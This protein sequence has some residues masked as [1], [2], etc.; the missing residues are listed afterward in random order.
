MRILQKNSPYE[1]KLTAQWMEYPEILRK[2]IKS[3]PVPQ[4]RDFYVIPPDKWTRAE[5][6]IAFIELEC[7]VPEGSLVG[8]KMSLLPFQRMFIR[9]VYDNPDTATRRAIL[10]M[11]RKNGKTSLVAPLVLAHIVGPEANRNSQIVSGAMSMRQ[12]GVLMDAMTKIIRFNPN[13]ESRS[14]ITGKFVRGIAKNVNY[15]CLARDG[16]TAQGLSPNVA[17][18]DEVGQIV[19]G[20]DKFVEAITTAQGAHHEPLLFAI[21]TQAAS[22]SDLLS[23]WID[24]AQRSEDPSTICHVYEADADCDLLDEEQWIKANPALGVFRNEQDLRVNL[25]RAARVPS[26]EAGARNLLLNQRVSLQTLAVSPQVWKKNGKEVNHDLFMREPVH[27]GLD[28]SSRNDLTACALSVMDPATGE[29]HVKPLVFTP[30]DSIIERSQRD[31]APYD[32]W[33]R[34]G[35]MIALPG[36]HM[37][38]DMIAETLAIHTRG[39]HIATVSYDRWR[40]NDFK[41]RADAHGFAQEAEWLPVGQGFKDFS[42]R[43]EGLESVLLQSKLHHG[44][45]P[46]FN[47]GASNAIVITDPTGNKKYDKSKSSQRIDTLVA[48]AMSVYPLSDGKVEVLDIGTMI[49]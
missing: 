3:G 43:V 21:S 47:L 39:M 35:H 36:T 22:D 27:A 44:F 30:L 37:D 4:D 29:I 26:A 31:R 20:V 28:L 7:C 10:T 38:Y 32:Q 42:L 16:K 23:I 17:V 19:G 18:L 6:L 33:V 34:D 9:A 45:H 8:Q 14:H 40:I 49:V 24:D 41:P 5:R 1:M 15:M 48:L 13:M 25:E 11:S 12:A 2:A 46:L